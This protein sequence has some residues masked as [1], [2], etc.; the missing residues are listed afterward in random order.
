MAI[1]LP[2]CCR[3]RF[4]W[5]LRSNSEREQILKSARKL[6]LTAGCLKE[7]Q[8]AG[9]QLSWEEVRDTVYELSK[10]MRILDLRAYSGAYDQWYFNLNQYVDAVLRIVTDDAT[11]SETYDMTGETP[12]ISARRALKEADNRYEPITI[13][14]ELEAAIRMEFFEFKTR[15][16]IELREGAPQGVV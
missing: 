1:S 16:D 13:F 15:W 8:N 3:A 12:G 14:L 2:L 11:F 7:K 6:H 9:D 10:R 4:R 5:L